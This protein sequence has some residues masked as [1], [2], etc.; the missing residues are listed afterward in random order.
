MKKTNK[1]ESLF[2]QLQDIVN[3][4]ESGE[5]SLEESVS[6]YSKGISLSKKIKNKLSILENK[7]QEIS[8]E[9]E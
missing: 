9:S 3:Q 1:L 5:L 2:S 7:I 8:K 4:L 6:R